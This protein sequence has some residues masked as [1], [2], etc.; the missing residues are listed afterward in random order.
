MFDKLIKY[1]LNERIVSWNQVVVA[2]LQG[3]A[4]WLDGE[5]YAYRTEYLELT[6]I[7]QAINWLQSAG[8]IPERK[9]DL[10]LRKPTGTDTYCWRSG[11]SAAIVNHC[12]GSHELAWLGDLVIALATTGLRISELAS[13][14][15]TDVDR[16]AKV[17][18]LTDESTRSRSR[19]TSR[20]RNQEQPKPEFSD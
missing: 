7:K 20:S 18:R 4:A 17:I 3:Y 5:G 2:T 14:R 8:H 10:P 12:H 13:L 6:T 9:I 19:G 1:A 15:I 11:R 16:V